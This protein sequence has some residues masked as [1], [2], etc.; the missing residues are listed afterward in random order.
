MHARKRKRHCRPDLQFV[1]QSPERSTM[2]GRSFLAKSPILINWKIFIEIF[3]QWKAIKDEREK[4]VKR[5]KMNV[6]LQFQRRTTTGKDE[7]REAKKRRK[8]NERTEEKTE[9]IKVIG[10]RE[11]RRPFDIKLVIGQKTTRSNEIK[12]LDQLGMSF[13]QIDSFSLGDDRRRADRTILIFSL[14]HFI[15]DWK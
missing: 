10:S 15:E 8:K 11:A 7:E 3:R 5:W 13:H 14:S 4:D 9:S 12:I 1:K 2:I 6:T